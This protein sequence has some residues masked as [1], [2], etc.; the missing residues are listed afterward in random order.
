[1]CLLMMKTRER[2][3]KERESITTHTTILSL[4]LSLLMFSKKVCCLAFSERLCTIVGALIV[5][6]PK[7]RQILKMDFFVFLT[8]S[9]KFLEIFSRFF[10]ILGSNP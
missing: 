2:Q 7:G 4:S 9:S 6:P 5:T 3:R 10:K 8:I 1:M